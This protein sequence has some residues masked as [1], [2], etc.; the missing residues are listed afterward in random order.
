V[1]EESD[2]MVAAPVGSW[3]EYDIDDP[4]PGYYQ[5]DSLSSRHPDLYH[6]FARS[7][8][9]L[10]DELAKI[11][12]LTDLVVVDVGA[13]TGR[14]THAAARLASTVY[15]VDAYPSVLEFSAREAARQGLENIQYLHA[16]RS[17]IPLPDTSV[18]AVIAAWAEVDHAEAMRLLRPGGLLVHMH[19]QDQWFAGEV[20]AALLGGGPTIDVD[21]PALDWVLD[22]FVNVHDFPYVVT[23][24]TADEAAAIYGRLMGPAVASY[25]R[26]RDQQTVAWA[27]RIYWMRVP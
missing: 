7:T 3:R 5:F 2:Y 11:V 6:E 15:A 20:T 12:D 23:Y 18:D 27:L 14:S 19:R 26:D 4:D 25:L 24:E 13:G 22:G 1:D 10:M 16:D 8:D 17:S 9:G 21:A